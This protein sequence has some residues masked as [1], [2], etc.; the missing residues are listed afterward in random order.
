MARQIP[1]ATLTL[2]ACLLAGCVSVQQHSSFR[3]AGCPAGNRSTLYVGYHLNSVRIDGEKVSLLGKGW[4]TAAWIVE[5]LPGRHQVEGVWVGKFS[6]EFVAERG[7]NYAVQ[8]DTR[9]TPV[10]GGTRVDLDRI[11]IVEL[12]LGKEHE[13]TSGQRLGAVETEGDKTLKKCKT[14][15]VLNPVS[16]QHKSN[17]TAGLSAEATLNLGV[18]GAEQRRAVE[19]KM[20]VDLSQVPLGDEVKVRT[21]N[22][23][24]YTVVRQTAGGRENIIELGVVSSEKRE[25][26]ETTLGVDL[27]HVPPDVPVRLRQDDNGKYFVLPAD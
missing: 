21:R 5:L 4:G 1:A 20:N 22:G 10:A 3:A 6:G 25:F 11:Y 8:T 16:I 2:A 13:V 12:P 14:V 7:H 26:V 19:E 18:L 27:S 17:G 15:A 23:K 9:H 24:N